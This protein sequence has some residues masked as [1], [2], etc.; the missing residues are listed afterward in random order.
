MTLNVEVLNFIVEE[1]RQ[2]A[3]PEAYSA[4][5]QLVQKEVNSVMS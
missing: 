5:V 2:F 3:T 1:L 4:W